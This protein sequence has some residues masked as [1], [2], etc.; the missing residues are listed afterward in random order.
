MERLSAPAPFNFD[1]N[2]SEKW[3]SWDTSSF[4][5]VLL[6]VIRSETRFKLQYC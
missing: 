6:K 4:I 3:K 1:G 2:I 5:S